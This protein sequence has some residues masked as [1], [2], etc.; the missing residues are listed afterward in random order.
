MDE[1]AFRKFLKHKG[2]A[3]HVADRIVTTVQAYATFLEKQIEGKILEKANSRDLEAYVAWIEQHGKESA[4]VTLW[5][6][7]SYYEFTNRQALARKAAELREKRTKKKRRP[8]L[9]SKFRGVNPDHVKKLVEFRVRNVEDMR[10]KGR[11][12]QQRAILAE[13]TGIPLEVIEDLVR[14]SDLS[15]IPGAKG[16]RARLYVDMG[17]HSI[18]MMA[19]WN[20]EE[21]RLKATEFVEKTGFEGIPP[22]PKEASNSVKTAKSLP[23]LIE[24]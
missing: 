18:P 23:K 24:W 6:L 22:L 3:S 2:K 10:Q 11:T 9:L 13:Q 19:K 4:K 8:F 15:R 12:P 21:L 16:I 5:A 14:L 20:P 1:E 17:I 7:S